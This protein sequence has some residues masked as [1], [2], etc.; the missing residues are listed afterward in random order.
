MIDVQ[1]KGVIVR[2]V[3]RDFLNPSLIEYLKKYPTSNKHKG[4]ENMR[5]IRG[6]EVMK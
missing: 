3:L 1:N 4:K 6:E 5:E 2:G